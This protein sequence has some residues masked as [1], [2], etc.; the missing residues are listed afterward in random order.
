MRILLTNDDGISA[1][2]PAGARRA[3]RELDGRRGR[4]DR[5]RLEPQCDRAQ[6]HHPLA[7]EGRGG[8]VRRRRPRLRDRR[9]AGRLRALRRPRPA[10]RSPGPDRLRDQPRRQPRR[11]HHLLRARSPRRSRG[12]CSGSRRSP[13]PSSRPAA[14]WATFGGRFDFT[15]AAAFTAA[16][17]ARLTSVR[18]PRPPWSTSTARRRAARGRGHPARQADLRRRAEARRGDRRDGRKRYEI[19]GFAARP[20]RSEGHRPARGRRRADLDHPDPLRPHRPRRP[21][22]PAR[23]GALERDAGGRAVP[24]TA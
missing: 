19:Y 1:A 2:G 13:S 5:P 11:R 3:L 16:L 21:R 7:A 4:R 17:V 8:R 12:S 14:A 22:A 9:H 18:C 20:T 15:V 10:R 24:P 6:H 23:A